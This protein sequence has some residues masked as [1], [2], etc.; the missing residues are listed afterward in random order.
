MAKAAVTPE[1]KLWLA[2]HGTGEKMLGGVLSSYF[3]E[4]STRI[5]TALGDFTAPTVSD[6]PSIF[7]EAAE[8]TLLMAAL[9]D[10][11]V[12][13]IATGAQTQLRLLRPAA[14]PATTKGLAD[15]WKKF[16][17]PAGIKKAISAAFSELEIQ[18]YWKAIQSATSAQLTGLLRKAMNDGVNG[19]QMAERVRKSLG[20]TGKVRAAAIARTETTSAYNAGHQVAYEDLADDD[21]ITGKKWKAIVDK[22]T[23][24]AHFKLNGVSVGVGAK[25]NVGGTMAPYPGWHGLPAKQRINCRCTTLA[26]FGDLVKASRK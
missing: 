17:L 23:R 21:L 9:A 1:L 14:S 26:T 16:K 5:L 18:P 15:V 6:V 11:L 10:P 20:D 3:A 2:Q 7:D 8:H 22:F 24:N 12:T 19:R 13:L 25:F 4:Q